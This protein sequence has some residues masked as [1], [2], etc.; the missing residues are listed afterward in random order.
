MQPR[1]VKVDNLCFDCI[2]IGSG[3]A[4]G[5]LT[6]WGVTKTK[7]RF[8]AA[9][10]GAGVSNWE[11]MV[12]DSGSPELET[13]TGKSAPWDHDNQE[14]SVRRTSPIHF[15]AVVTTAVLIL[16]GEKDER[17]PVNQ[18]IGMWR[19]SRGVRQKEK[20]KPRSWCYT[21]GNHTV[22]SSASMQKM[23]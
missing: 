3:I 10:V 13:E 4:G 7:T 6:A 17:V 23:S 2:L 14:R 22:L 12:M 20:G 15:V 1:L 9:I 8:K 16:H 18:G 11:G 5:S 19:S 21:Q